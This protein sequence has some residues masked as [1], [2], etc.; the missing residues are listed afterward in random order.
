[1][2]F[3][4]ENT[5][6]HEDFC[7]WAFGQEKDAAIWNEGIDIMNAWNDRHSEKL[8]LTEDGII[9][10]NICRM[11]GIWALEGYPDGKNTENKEQSI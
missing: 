5:N 6:L 11:G 7:R 3:S 9:H 1:M 4:L 2:S 8:L 10:E